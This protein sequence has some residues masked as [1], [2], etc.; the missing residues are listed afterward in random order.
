MKKTIVYL[1]P[2]CVTDTDL[3]VLH[4]LAKEYHVVWYYIHESEKA[5]NR[6]TIAQAADY[7]NKYGLELRVKDLK[8]RFRNPKNFIFYAKIAKEINKI[9][10]DLVFHCHCDP[11]WCVAIKFFLRCKKVVLGIHD[12]QIHSYNMNLSRYL[13]CFSKNLAIKLHCNFV[14]FS[15]GQQKLFKDVYGKDSYMVGMSC[16][17]F[18][19]S[20]LKAPNISKGVKLLFFGSINV[21]KGLD[22]LISS[23]EKLRSQNVQNLSLTIAGTGDA[24]NTC[25]T[26]IQTKD[27]YN[28][29]VRFIDNNEI[30]DLM[31]SHHFLVLPYRDATQSGPLATA[32]A[33]ELPVVA[34][35]FGFFAETYTKDSAILYTQGHLEEALI[36]V[37]K[38]TP[39]NYEFL[40]AACKKIKD[41]YS[42]ERIA[43]NYIKCFNELMTKK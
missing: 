34:P 3:T 19:K 41:A 12:A 8:H 40:K 35:D 26:L 42:E 11:Y 28:L 4:C 25:K 33:Y 31:S 21:Y 15:S 39:D 20:E 6:I 23:L 1:N 37:S 24:W 13:E 22:L 14:T 5:Y 29:Q 17:Y 9:S 2:D 32:V 18:G 43:Q 7:A 27:M 10:P 16:K 30:P 36:N 38:L